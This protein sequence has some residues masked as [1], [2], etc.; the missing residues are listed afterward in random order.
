MGCSRKGKS[1]EKSTTIDD[2]GEQ[3]CQELE[4]FFINYNRLSGEK[5]RVIRVKGPG[6][7]RKLVKAGMR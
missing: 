7:A 5:Y 2:L 6:Q 3:F 1:F 4:E